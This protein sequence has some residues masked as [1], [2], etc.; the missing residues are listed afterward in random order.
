MTLTYRAR[1]SDSNTYKN[2][3]TVTQPPSQWQGFY[4]NTSVGEKF[5]D[6]ATDGVLLSDTF[7][8]HD[9]WLRKE[10]Q[11]MSS[12]WIFTVTWIEVVDIQATTWSLGCNTG[13]QA[14]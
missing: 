1:P 11:K 10:S 7:A 9:E 6:Y 4:R 13:I 12:L 5:E 8:N 3:P 2:Y 14:L